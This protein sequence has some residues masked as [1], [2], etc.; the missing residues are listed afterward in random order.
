MIVHST[1]HLYGYDHTNKKKLILWK[2]KKKMYSMSYSKG[3]IL[4]YDKKFFTRIASIFRSN[5]KEELKNVIEDLID[6]NKNGTEKID[7][8]TKNIFK[9]VINLS[10]KCIEDI[11]IPRADIDAVSSDIKIN[12]LVSFINKNKHSRIPVFQDNL[13][14][15]I[16]MIHIRDLF[17]KVN[18]KV[19]N[20]RNLKLSKT[21]IERFFSHLPQ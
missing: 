16:G 9:N 19:R 7:D 8:G 18:N 11:M 17:E 21:I 10:D 3:K 1:L 13:D 6:E 5:E 14:R 2:R 15:I 20:N 4:N 12:N